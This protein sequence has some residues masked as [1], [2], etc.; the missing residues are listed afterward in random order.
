MISVIFL[1]SI[2]WFG[3][4]LDEEFSLSRGDFLVRLASAI[5][6]GAFWGAWIVFLLSWASGFSLHTVT[7]GMALILG[8]NLLAWRFR[9]RDPAWFA[10]LFVFDKRFWQA[11]FLPTALITLYFTVCVWVNRDGDILFRGNTRD[12]AFHMGTVSAFMEQSAFPPLNPQSAAAKLSYHF[13]TDFFA[14]IL[15]KGGFSLFYSLK[16]PMVLFAFSLCSLTCH[17]LYSVLKTRAATV[18]A[19]LL[20]FFGHIGVINL[21][22][23]LAGHPVGEGPLAL[24]SWS[25]IENTLVYPYYNFLNVVIDFFQPQLPFLFGFPLAMLVL[26]VLYRKFSQQ[27]TTDRST[28]FIL[29]MVAFLPLFHMHT[30]LTIAPLVGLLMLYEPEPSQPP[31]ISRNRFAAR[32]FRQTVGEA[33]PAPGDPG[34]TSPVPSRTEGDDY[35]SPHASL[36]ILAI[37]LAAVPVALQLRFIFSQEKAPG[38]SGFDVPQHLGPMPEIPA[39]LHL[40]RFWF[41]IRAAGVPLVIGLPAVFLSFRIRRQDTDQDRRGKIA[42]L[43]LL[44]VAGFYFLVI[45]FFRFTPNWGDSNKFFLYLDLVL[46]L[47]AGWLLSFFWEKSAVLRVAACLLVSLGAIVPTTI[48]WVTRYSREPERLFSASDRLVADWIR[49]NTPRDAVFL[50]ANSTVHLVPA[51]AGRR[52]VNGAYTRET[53]FAS[54]DI[55]DLVARAYRE[56]DPS[57]ITQTT[58]THVMVGPEEEGVY[59]VNRETLDQCLNRIFDLTSR[60]ARYSIYE[61]H[62]YSA[63]ELE[64]QRRIAGSRPF[65]WL[66]ELKPASVEQYGTLRFDR[67]FALTPLKL[68]ERTYSFGLG[69]HAPSDI[70]FDL[71]GA[72]SDFESDIGVD[73]SQLGG[74]GSV[75]FQVWLDDRKV[76]ESA[77]MHAGDPPQAIK[78]DISGVTALRLVVTDAGDGNHCDHA[79]WAGARLFRKR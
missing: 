67:A 24:G 2:L 60:G 14:A 50:T 16:I 54:Q 79:D 74:I 15:D 64:H 42:L 65:I 71:G 35:Q 41:W 23:S 78:I 40:Q 7:G 44:A 27:T 1:F 11:S 32:L 69:T 30:F 77:I 47:Y 43:A 70:R 20:F 6:L 25:S 59:Q 72:Y 3:F 46:C 26:V 58:V 4:I 12:L 61:S 75:V 56:S 10:S 36:K 18:F 19:G 62:R 51:L 68:F 33:S 63:E 21:L 57:L 38:F 22:F 28:Y 76:F 48:E 17:F 5:I 31:A 45:N 9:R 13:M 55:E 37:L 49:I 39:F 29:G 66:S 53:G 34:Q 52:A 73:D 8:F